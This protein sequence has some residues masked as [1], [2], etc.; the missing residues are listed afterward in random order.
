MPL[1]LTIR[2]SHFFEALCATPAIILLS[3][4]RPRPCDHHIRTHPDIDFAMWEKSPFNDTLLENVELRSQIT[5][6]RL[7]LDFGRKMYCAQVLAARGKLPQHR[8]ALDDKVYYTRY[9]LTE[10]H[11]QL[12]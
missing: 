7:F 3:T 11:E 1:N 10:V 9:S 4:S 5:K 8:V 12:L 2:I 6:L